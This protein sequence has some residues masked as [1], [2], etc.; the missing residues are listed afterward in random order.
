MKIDKYVFKGYPKQDVP[1]KRFLVKIDNLDILNRVSGYQV[2]DMI[3][4]QEKDEI[5]TRKIKIDGNE[6]FFRTKEELEEPISKEGFEDSTSRMHHRNRLVHR[7]RYAFPDGMISAAILANIP[8]ESEEGR[9]IFMML[10][11][12]DLWQDYAIL[13]LKGSQ[14]KEVK[15]LTIPGLELVK[16]ITDDMKYCTKSFASIDSVIE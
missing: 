6:H 2:A 8:L 5:R 13:T 9:G 15:N 11:T 4:C 16:E 7:M 10:D 3:D 1:E 12:F 14:A